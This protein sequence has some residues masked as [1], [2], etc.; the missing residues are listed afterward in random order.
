MKNLALH[1]LAIGASLAALGL[2][3][4]TC[5]SQQKL[6]D[7]TASASTA[8]AMPHTTTFGAAAV[9]GQ[10]GPMIY[11]KSWFQDTWYLDGQNSVSGGCASDSNTTCSINNCST[12][13]DG[14]C[15]TFGSIATRWGSYCPNFKSLGDGGANTVVINLLS[16]M[17][18]TD[19][20]YLCH[21]LEAQTASLTFQGT[22][23]QVAQVT[24]G[25]VTS[26]ARGS[27]TPG[28]SQ[29]LNA[30][31]VPD[32]GALAVGQFLINTGH[33]SRAWVL[34][35]VSGSTWAISQP[36][37]ALIPGS[38]PGG[39][40]EVDT[41]APSDPVSVYTLPR[42]NLASVEPVVPG[43]SGQ[44]S[45]YFYNVNLT[46]LGFG[47]SQVTKLTQAAIIESFA[48]TI[49]DFGDANYALQNR[50]GAFNSWANEGYSSSIAYNLTDFSS[51]V[52]GDYAIFAGVIPTSEGSLGHVN[53]DF[54]VI[55]SGVGG[56]SVPVN[57]ASIGLVYTAGA[58]INVQGPGGKA[59]F[60]A[61]AGAIPSGQ[62]ILW[63][64]GNIETQANSMIIYLNGAGEAASTF[65]QSG[66]WFMNGQHTACLALP[67]DA[68]SPV[69]NVAVSASNAFVPLL[70]TLLG[71]NRG[72]VY[73]PGG[74]SICNFGKD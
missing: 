37:T 23:N 66:S 28:S 55:L 51:S 3:F 50:M 2:S 56:T 52:V 18:S 53:L 72:C 12:P 25:T 58:T 65:L 6:A 71:P 47:N 21:R 74:S 5:H 39:M 8:T 73:V 19:F 14:P 30:V 7:A 22:L 11:P 46:N 24:L 40:T 36:M 33:A 54:D 69:C 16:N 38:N 68:S 59:I 1:A 67:S 34:S 63:G 35:D 60:N 45:T 10:P 44:A 17:L 31:M 48:S 57:I 64:P 29:L 49:I 20:V 32:G 15:Q 13:G 4:T 41:W 27:T 43:Q 9:P 26:K 61:N 42:L 62:T 70:D